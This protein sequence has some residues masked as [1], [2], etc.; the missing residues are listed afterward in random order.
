[1]TLPRL[2]RNR[3][4][5]LILDSLHDADARRGLQSMAAI[6]AY[7]TA[8]V[9]IA[10]LPDCAL[11]DAFEERGGSLQLKDGWKEY[12]K[13]LRERSRRAWRAI[14]RRPLDSPGA[15]L[16]VALGVA[17]VLFDAGLYYEVH[18]WLERY[19]LCAEGADREALQG[20]IQIAV[21]F[22]HLAHGNARG[23]AAL[24]TAGCRKVLGRRLEG[25]DLDSFGRATHACLD[26]IN[27]RGATAPRESDRAAV[28]RFPT[29]PDHRPRVAR[30]R[31]RGR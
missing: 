22:E 15:P 14:G 30:K 23:A 19:W 27:A 7:P 6:S 4:A 10:D 11:R 12:A 1:M 18:E 16:G 31:R 9:R 5:D 26:G 24:L 8:R 28:P 3:L 29:D 25:L 2:L 20:L 17:A 13:D 21:G